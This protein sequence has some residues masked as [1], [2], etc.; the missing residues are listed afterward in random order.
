MVEVES[1]R[2]LAIQTIVAN[3]DALGMLAIANRWVASIAATELQLSVH[4]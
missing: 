4:I 2:Q 3:L 1:L